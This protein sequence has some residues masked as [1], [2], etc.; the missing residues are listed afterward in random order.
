[1]ATVVAE[2]GVSITGSTGLAILDIFCLHSVYHLGG[3]KKLA[4]ICFKLNVGDFYTVNYALKKFI[5]MKLIGSKKHGRKVFYATTPFG[6]D[7]CLRYPAICEVCLVDGLVD[8]D[9]GKGTELSE[10]ARQ[11]CLLSG[12]HDQAARS[13]TSL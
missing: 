13:A 3:P 5:K 2:T 7:L 6:V 11:L 8:L 10:V 9:G 4:D 12:L 1:M